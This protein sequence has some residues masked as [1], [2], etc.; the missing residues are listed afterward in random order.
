MRSST[1]IPPSRDNQRKL[2]WRLYLPYG[3]YRSDSISLVLE[4]W[5]RLRC[6][7]SPL[8]IFY[9]SKRSFLSLQLMSHRFKVFVISPI[10]C[11]NFHYRFITGCVT[12]PP[13]DNNIVTICCYFYILWFCTDTVTLVDLICKCSTASVESLSVTSSLIHS[14]T[15]YD[16]RQINPGACTSLCPHITTFIWVILPKNFPQPNLPNFIIKSVH[17]IY[18]I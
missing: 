8:C 2:V 7:L 9:M 14:Y 5:E 4:Q 3:S 10:A 15:L 18:Q 17:N 6:L 12:F 1:N 16:I 13:C 11:T